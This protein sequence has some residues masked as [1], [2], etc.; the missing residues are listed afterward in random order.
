MQSILII[1]K[2]DQLYK[3]IESSQLE[4]TVYN[5]VYD[6]VDDYNEKYDTVDRLVI[7]DSVIGTGDN[8]YNI[9]SAVSE[10]LKKNKLKYKQ[11]CFTVANANT[12]GDIVQI[13]EHL[14]PLTKDELTEV[15]YTFPDVMTILDLYG[16]I[17]AKQTSN[18]KIQNTYDIVIK[19]FANADLSS[20]GIE[21]VDGTK[22]SKDISK[23]KFSSRDY[24][25]LLNYNSM[26]ALI[27]ARNGEAKEVRQT[28]MSSDFS[29][30]IGK[31]PDTLYSEDVKPNSTI[32]TLIT[33]LPCSGKST[34]LTHIVKSIIENEGN[35]SICVFDMTNTVSTSTFPNEID[36]ITSIHT[37]SLLASPYVLDDFLLHMQDKQVN[38]IYGEF[39]L[40]FEMYNIFKDAAPVVDYIPDYVFVLIS[41]ED[42]KTIRLDD[43]GTILVTTVPNS[44]HFKRVL[45]ASVANFVE[46]RN[47]RIVYIPS[48]L[49]GNS[50]SIDGIDTS[51]LG[52]F[53]SNSLKGLDY[54]ANGIQIDLA[55]TVYLPNME[56]SALDYPVTRMLLGKEAES[57]D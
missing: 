22:E 23:H 44:K 52:Q 14:F 16:I 6:F 35:K 56:L 57:D 28:V 30:L 33:G 32:T 13:I 9:L 20:L 40:A 24:T 29:P 42:A 45:D 49:S 15:I 18:V 50:T 43:Y 41:I 27:A 53:I 46:A 2:N 55:N 8:A 5:D 34:L 7:A 10:T 51:M 31:V 39:T 3:L 11:L 1:K 47:K 21:D 36:D 26:R 54:K 38:H 17:T 4:V 25:E 37:S 19:S 12:K 48:N